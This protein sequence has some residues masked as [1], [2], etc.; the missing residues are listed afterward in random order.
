MSFLFNTLYAAFMEIN[1]K[2]E[3]DKYGSTR[4][5][6]KALGL[7]KS[8]FVFKYRKQQSLCTR[9]GR[10]PRRHKNMC[11]KCSDNMAQR[12]GLTLVVDSDKACPNCNKIFKVKYEIRKV[13]K[14]CSTSCRSSYHNKGKNNPMYVHGEAKRKYPIEFYKIRDYILNR[15]GYS[16]KKC[17]IADQ[18]LYDVHHIDFN[19][20]NNNENNL[21]TLCKQ[22]HSKCHGTLLN[23]KESKKYYT[24]FMIE[25]LKS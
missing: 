23:R 4:K 11:Q 20:F 9:C 24:N 5:A 8:S 14:F 17:G 6:A 15:D 13:Q 16:C 10:I 7:T 25:Y 22:C 2:K 12:K 19:K 18:E 21:I 3:L 1:Y